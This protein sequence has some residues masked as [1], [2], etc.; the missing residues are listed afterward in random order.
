MHFVFTQNFDTH[1]DIE[2]YKSFINDICELVVRRFD[3]AL[4]AEHGTG[5][6]MA[7]F[8]EMEWGAKAYSYMKQLKKA[9]D[10][11]GLLNPDVLLT[12]NSNV[13]VEN[14]K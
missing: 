6:N 11:L 12:D 14:L 7:P 8:V 2:R 4:K 9:F 1:D 10:P 13:Y 3:G 5:R